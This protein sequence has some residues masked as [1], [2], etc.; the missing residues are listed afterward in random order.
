MDSGKGA[1][2]K[3]R[4]IIAMKIILKD[5]F[6]GWLLI[7]Q[8]AIKLCAFSCDIVIIRCTTLLPPFSYKWL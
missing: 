2:K 3:E 8:I 7:L 5:N 4:H 1:I 6:K